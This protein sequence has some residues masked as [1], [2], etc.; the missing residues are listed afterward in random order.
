LTYTGRN[1]RCLVFDK[2][3]IITY[4]I[5]QKVSALVYLPNKASIE[6]TFQRREKV[7][8]MSFPA[9]TV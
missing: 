2:F 6:I 7:T 3:L 8:L 5:S 1:S 9:S 4:K